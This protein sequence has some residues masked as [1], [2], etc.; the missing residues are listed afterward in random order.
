MVAIYTTPTCA[1]CH[2]LKEY[3]HHKKITF[4]EKD[5]ASNKENQQWILDHAGQLATPVTDFNGTIIIGFN[6]PEIDK[7]IRNMK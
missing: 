4:T 5:V 2:S 3:L 1:F 6:K 7:A